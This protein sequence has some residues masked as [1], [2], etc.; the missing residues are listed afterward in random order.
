MRVDG[1]G[2]SRANGSPPPTSSTRSATLSKA[3]AKADPSQEVVVQ[4]LR[5]ERRLGLFTQAFTT[6]FVAFVGERSA[7]LQ[8]SRID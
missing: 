5:R 6:S 1:G 2:G 8:L 7:H 3:L 4:A